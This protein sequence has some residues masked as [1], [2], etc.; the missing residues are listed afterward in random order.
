MRAFGVKPL[1]SDIITGYKW[2]WPTSSLDLFFL[3]DQV[4]R[5]SQCQSLDCRE[6]FYEMFKSE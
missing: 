4:F 2:S 3:G 6:V 5:L 1:Y